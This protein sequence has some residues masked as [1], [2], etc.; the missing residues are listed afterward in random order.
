MS[1]PDRTEEFRTIARELAAK[2]APRAA[3]WDQTQT[4]CWENISDLVDAGLMG[5]T[6]PAGYGGRSASFYDT[7]VVVEEIAKACTLSA[8]IAVESNMG[9]IS[10]IMAYG[11]DFQKSYCAPIVLAGD[12][13]AICITEPEAG[14]AANE[15]QTTARKA[16]DEYLINGVKHWI[17]GGGV[18]KLYL[19]FARVEDPDGKS[20]GI[21]AFIV[22]RDPE[23]GINPKGFTVEGR[24][25][26]LGLRGMPE[27]RLRFDD[28]KVDARFMLRTP[29]G[30]R[31]GFAEL[32]S[33]YNSQRVGAGTIAMGVAA[34]ALDHA[35]RYLKTRHQ[36]GR[37]IAE[38][39]G[40]QWMIAQMDASVH[41]SRLLLH[42]AARSGGSN[43]S[44]FPDMLSAARAKLFA[45]ETAI[46][47]VSDSLQMFGARGYG[48]QEPLERMFRDVRMFTIGGG[49]A[50]ILKTQIG[51]S[52]LGIKSPQTRDGFHRMV[53]SGVLK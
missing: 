17:T 37:P 6:I 16:G 4:Y 8:R 32:M 10:A 44:P 33:A 12:K 53:Q 46:Q 38:F 31:R 52:L 13:P 19:I 2:F 24:E 11:D 50:Q 43:G 7:V 40:L 15:M 22:H 9:G 18:S 51:S 34:G 29:S 42:E 5:M 26:T 49:T 14:S 45:S 30:L 48:D 41:A 23:M 35:K 20:L 25:N 1:R 47:V 28:L 27:A 21:G 36:F 3:K 39:Q